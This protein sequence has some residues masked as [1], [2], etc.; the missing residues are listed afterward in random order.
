L[1]ATSFAEHQRLS[2][3]FALLRN[4]FPSLLFI[5]HFLLDTII[6]TTIATMFECDTCTARFFSQR[7]CD[8]HMNDKGHWA[9]TF[10]CESCTREFYSEHAANQHMSALGHW[11]P[12]VPCE[13][14]GKRFYTQSAANQHM[15][16]VGHWKPTIPC[17]MCELN[18]YT[19][20]AAHE[21]MR[22]N[23]HYKNYCR[24]CC[25][26]FQNQNNLQMARLPTPPRPVKVHKIL[27]SLPVAS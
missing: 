17:E 21:H 22:D 14:C 12:H 19:E 6:L 9:P 26:Q 3:R 13:T 11:K 7:A 4:A 25:R 18:F 8:Q 1:T 27:T 16:A 15:N 23:G 20:K 5:P 10:E 24:D 2:S